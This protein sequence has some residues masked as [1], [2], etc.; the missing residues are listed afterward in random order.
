[1]TPAP[2]PPAPAAR[3]AEAATLGLEGRVAL[4]T[5]ASR[6]L[7]RAVARKL[8][9]SGCDVYLNYAT[10]D[11]D[12]ERAVESLRGLKGTAVAV[13][14]DITRPDTL[15]ALLDRITDRHGRLDVFVHNAA[16]F[17]PM[18]TLSA[19]VADVHQDVAA[20]VDPLLH[21]AAHLAAAMAGGPG[22]IVAVSSLGAQ[23]VVPRYVG[24]GL[25]KAALESLVRYLAVELAPQGIAV[26]AVAT[27]KLDKGEPAAVNPEAARALAART[28][29]GRLTRPE[30]LADAVALLCTDE[31]AW[32]HGQV[33]TVDG[34]SRLRA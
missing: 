22:R 21:G 12:A 10:N 15:P 20:A 6:G 31:A 30:D 2:A 14:G 13:K 5:G 8:C 23:A 17:H 3:A 16:S 26:N 11:T 29:A 9:A 4:V 34:G 32:I 1:M 19:A 33:I 7:G 25:A 27:A 28:P 18:P 24:L